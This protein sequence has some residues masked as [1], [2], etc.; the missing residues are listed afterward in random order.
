[1]IKRRATNTENGRST[2]CLYWTCRLWSNDQILSS[3]SSSSHDYD[4]NTN[5]STTTAHTWLR[6]TIMGRASLQSSGLSRLI[7]AL[8]SDR[9]VGIRKGGRYRA[10]CRWRLKENPQNIRRWEGTS[11]ASHAMIPRRHGK[12]ISNPNFHFVAF[13]AKVPKSNSG[14]RILR[15]SRSNDHMSSSRGLKLGVYVKSRREKSIRKVRWLKS[16]ST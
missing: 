11:W 15:S 1:M 9:Q 16:Q 12:H 4:P 6:H 10:H 13:H 7:W 2:V 3:L 5:P 14:L 8:V